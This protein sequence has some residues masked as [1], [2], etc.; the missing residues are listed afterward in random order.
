MEL[1]FKLEGGIG[2]GGPIAFIYNGFR[3]GY[4]SK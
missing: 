4:V 1:V 3:V 2:R